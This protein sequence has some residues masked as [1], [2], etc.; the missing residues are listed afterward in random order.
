MRGE[1]TPVPQE[2]RNEVLMRYHLRSPI[3]SGSGGGHMLDRV[4]HIDIPNFICPARITHGHTHSATATAGNWQGF[5][6]L[7]SS[8]ELVERDD[9]G[10]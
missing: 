5:R 6:L 10:L 9:C 7:I 1:S 2:S 3:P 4:F 8:P